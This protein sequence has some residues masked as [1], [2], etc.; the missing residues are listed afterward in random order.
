MV[1][2]MREKFVPTVLLWMALLQGKT[3]FL[4]HAYSCGGCLLTKVI[5]LFHLFVDNP[6]VQWFLVGT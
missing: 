3:L 5:Q 2:A 4:P 6:H 1:T